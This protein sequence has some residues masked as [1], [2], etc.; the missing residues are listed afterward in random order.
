MLKNKA[1]LGQMYLQLLVTVLGV[2]L[3]EKKQSYLWIVFVG[4]C[5]MGISFIYTARRYKEIKDLTTYVDRIQHRVESLDIRDNREG[6]L[7][8][9]KNEIYKLTLKLVNQAELLKKDKTY[10]ADSISDISHQLKTPLTSMMVMADL[11]TESDLPQGKQAE[12]LHNIQ[13]GLERMQW[14]V[15]SLLK[16]SK[17][18]ADAVVLK[19]ETVNVEELIKKAT[20]PLLIPMEFKNQELIIEGSSDVT[21]MGDRL[22]TIEAIGNIIKN[23][24]EHT[25]EGGRITISYGQNNLYTNIVI[26]DNGEGID[27]EDLPHIFER[28]YKG[29]NASSDSVGIGLALS[30][31]I[32]N[33]QKATVEVKSTPLEGSTFI[34]KFYV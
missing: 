3:Y 19:R 16:L 28:F 31:S 22:W 33:R 15:Q 4:L 12:F 2:V 14:L 9:L 20:E 7:S 13:S 21:F 27:K 24:M 25:R 11:L 34:I 18:D 30:K 17:L 5:L 10:L 32:L 23:C 26:K 1:F 8:V 29:K 6:E